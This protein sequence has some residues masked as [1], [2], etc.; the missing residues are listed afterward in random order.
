MQ[1]TEQSNVSRYTEC[2]LAEL[3]AQYL[4]VSCV[5]LISL[6]QAGKTFP[7]FCLALLEDASPQINIQSNTQKPCFGH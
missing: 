7:L 2:A 5:Q 1:P 4:W 3:L 6:P